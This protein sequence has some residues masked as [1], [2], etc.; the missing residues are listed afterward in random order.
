MEDV[1]HCPSQESVGNIF[2]GHGEINKSLINKRKEGRKGKGD[3]G[4]VFFLSHS[5][6]SVR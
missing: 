5:R 1:L 2:V 6:T 4:I 3:H